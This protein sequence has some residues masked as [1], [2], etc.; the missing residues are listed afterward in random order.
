MVVTGVETLSTIRKEY[1]RDKVVMTVEHY[2][3]L[4]IGNQQN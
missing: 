3:Y 4:D 2:T 1:G